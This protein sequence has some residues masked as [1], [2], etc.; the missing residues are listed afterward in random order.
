MEDLNVDDCSLS[1]VLKVDVLQ[2]VEIGFPM[3]TLG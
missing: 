1:D 3:E 2:V